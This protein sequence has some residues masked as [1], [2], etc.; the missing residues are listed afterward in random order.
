MIELHARKTAVGFY[1]KMNYQI[2]PDIFTEVGLLH[3]RM[4]KSLEKKKKS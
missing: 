1:L 3:Y 2:E 4:Y